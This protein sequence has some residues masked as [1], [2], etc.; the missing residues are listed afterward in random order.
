MIPW[1]Q[2]AR[3]LL[4]AC[5][6]GAGTGVGIAAGTTARAALSASTERAKKWHG[7]A[8]LTSI[9]S[10][11]VQPDGRSKTWLYMFHSAGSKAYLIVTVK[12][13]NLEEMEVN[14]GMSLPITGDFLDSDK[15][16][17]E[18]KKNGLKGDDISVG[19]NVGGIGSSARL[20]WSVN[21]G[22]E[23]GDVSVTLD[24]KTGAFV[25][26]DVMPGF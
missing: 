26:R 16:V 8:V 15:A 22:M 24:G 13:K 17:A 3:G 20:Y 14:S 10:Y 6:I 9:S 4:V 7:D 25:K 12:G 1:V 18:A 19:L 11:G 21:G 2:C 5:L 23:K